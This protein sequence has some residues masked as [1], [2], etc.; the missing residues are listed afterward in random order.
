MNQTKSKQI[1]FFFLKS[2]NELLLQTG[3]NLALILRI[4]VTSL[5]R[6]KT[7]KKNWEFKQNEDDYYYCT[8]SILLEMLIQN[9]NQ[10]LL[11]ILKMWLWYKLT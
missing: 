7:F 1:V 2:T 3:T 9:E 4:L 5:I 8:E 6:W 10:T 11:A